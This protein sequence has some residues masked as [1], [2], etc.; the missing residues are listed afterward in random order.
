MS[1]RAI[2]FDFD[3]VLAD[4]EPIHF[5]MFREV[6]K[7]EGISLSKSVYYE[8]YLGLDD[9]ACFA[10]VYK[11]QG[12]RLE[13][14]TRESLIQNK[15]KALLKFV[16]GRPVLLP[17]VETFVE[18]MMNQNYFLAIVSGALK[19]EIL[20]ILD[21]VGLRDKFHVIVA[22]DDVAQGK[23]DPEGFLMAIRLLNRDFIPPAEILFGPECL[24]IEDSPWGIEAAHQAGAPCLGVLTSYPKNRLC[25]ADLLFPDL[26]SVSWKAVEKLFR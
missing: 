11:D 14:A 3:G 23:P 26:A 25:E 7:Q 19:S 21:G 9:R 6:L 10:A 20:A 17:G 2:L 4:T 24:A 16:D 8:K 12:R 15:N 22:A 13:A 5:A 1:L 18:K